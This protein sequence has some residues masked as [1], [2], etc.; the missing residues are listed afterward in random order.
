MLWYMIQFNKSPSASSVVNLEMCVAQLS[1]SR[2]IAYQQ[3]ASGITGKVDKQ[4]T[5]GPA[6]QP[7]LSVSLLGVRMEGKASQVRT[8]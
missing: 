5:V 3:R 6:R 8:T 1:A 2:E 4:R 7:I